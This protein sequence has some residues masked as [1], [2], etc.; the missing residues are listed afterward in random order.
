MIVINAI[1]LPHAVWTDEHDYQAIA[2]Q[3]ELAINGAPHIEKTKLPG[4]PITIESV[5]ETAS[6]YIA[7]FDHS[8][9][10]LTAFDISIRG[11]VYTVVWDHS[12]KPCTGSAV[13]YYS[14]AVPDFFENIT[15]RLKVV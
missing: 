5:L 6:A 1:E 10:T 4:R 12:Q 2:E 8:R 3:T 7:L 9:T 11:T 14:D 15:L 13:S